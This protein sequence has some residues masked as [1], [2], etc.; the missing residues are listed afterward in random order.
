M[1]NTLH[2]GNRDVCI[3]RDK[4]VWSALLNK[5][6]KSFKGKKIIQFSRSRKRGKCIKKKHSQ[7]HR[8]VKQ[9]DEFGEIEVISC[10]SRV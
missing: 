4:R 2:C 1:Y 9:Q 10:V 6:S 5:V 3:D 8:K 7:C